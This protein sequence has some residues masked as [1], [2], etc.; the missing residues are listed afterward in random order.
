MTRP[1]PWEVANELWVVLEPLLP[2]VERRIRHPGRKRHP[3]RLVFQD[4]LFVLHTGSAREH[5]PQELG[6]GSGMT[7]WRRLAE[8]TAAG[9]WPPLHELLL[10][11]LRGVDALDF[12]R[13][14]VD[15]SH[16]RAL[17]GAPRP[18]EAPLTGAGRAA[19]IT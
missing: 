5:L 17:K 16:I 6:F 8:W 13:A 14:A 18:D 3:D 9:V 2:K 15:G 12:S 11:K 10:A 7:C 4:I 19:S 1:K